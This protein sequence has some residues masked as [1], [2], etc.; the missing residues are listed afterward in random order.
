MYHILIPVRKDETRTR[1]QVNAVSDL[2][3]RSEEVSVTVLYVFEEID[4]D[5]GGTLSLQEYDDVPETV[6][7]AR[8]ALE[9]E[10]F[11]VDALV[12]EGHP[13]DAIVSLASDR[14]VDQIVLGGRKRSP[15]GKA[16]FGST[17]QSVILDADVPVTVVPEAGSEEDR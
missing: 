11:D 6:T 8:D 9:D 3:V 5:L 13:D 1:R 7:W 17:V 10:G 14:D 16:I 12:A 2:P 4:S 15:T